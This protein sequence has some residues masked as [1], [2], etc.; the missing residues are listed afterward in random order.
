MNIPI[1][2][3]KR[4]YTNLKD[5]IGQAIQ[6]V[7]ESTQF[8]LGPNLKELENKIAAYCNVRYGIGVANGTDALELT[9]KALNIGEGDEVIT[10]PFTFIASAEVASK[11]GAKPVFADIDPDTYLIDVD[12]IE[13]K[14]T[15]RTKAIIPVHIFGQMCD[16]DKMMKIAEK[17]NLYIIEDSCQAIGSEYKGKKSSSFGIA[18][19][20]SFYPTKNL[21]GY[22]DGGMIVTDDE[23]LAAKLKILRAHGSNPKYYHSMFGYNSRLDELQAAILNVKFKYLD[24]WN[25]RRREIAHRYNEKLKVKVPKEATYEQYH[26][27][28]QYTIEVDDR[29]QFEDYMKANGIGTC[30]YYPV[31]LHLQEV[32]KSLGYKKGDFPNTEKACKRVISIPISPEMTADEQEHVIATINNFFK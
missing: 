26:T 22:G 19:C 30:I 32:Y 18:G 25:R 2:D 13:E 1:L 15:E 20:F 4:Q 9:L 29:K 21:G 7:L 31:P 11:V 8:I 3:L 17:H 10:T 14:I 16:M 28:H 23:E 12:K 24:E 27:Y 5:E 6:G